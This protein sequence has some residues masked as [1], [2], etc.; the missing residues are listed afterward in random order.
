MTITENNYLDLGNLI[1]NELIGSVSLT[2]IIGIILIVF[3][4]VRE[5]L[6]IQ[7]IVAL[8]VLWTGLITAYSYNSFLLMLVIFIV[9]IGIY[10]MWP[11]II[12]R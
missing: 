3:F 10:S 4:G 9:A 5:R 1:I 12:K 6:D 11:K 8:C 7:A 2:I